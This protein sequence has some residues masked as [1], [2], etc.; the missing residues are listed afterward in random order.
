MS[1]QRERLNDI[2]TMGAMIASI[3]KMDR[4]LPVMM[5]LALRTVSGE[6]GAILLEENGELYTKVA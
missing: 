6:V 1:R 5:E 2:E 3:L 4:V